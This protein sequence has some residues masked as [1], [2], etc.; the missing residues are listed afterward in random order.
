M[1][2]QGSYDVLEFTL[3]TQGMNR[4]VSVDILPRAFAYTL[5]NILS[6]PLGEGQVRYGTSLLTALP[7]PEAVILKSFPFIQ[8]GG[9]EQM[10]F[11]VQDY[12][13]DQSAFDFELREGDPYSFTFET[14]NDNRYVIDTQIG[15]AHV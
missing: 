3:P 7:N 6:K 2:Q 13:Q 9:A 5:E 12:I 11:Y 15:R 4:Q 10:V 14:S 8:K 1:F